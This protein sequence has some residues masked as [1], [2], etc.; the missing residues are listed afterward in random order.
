[1]TEFEIHIPARKKAVVSER[2]MAVKVTGEAY[3]ALTEIYNESTLSM[4]Q[5]A[6]L[7]IVEGSKHIVYDKAEV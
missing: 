6:S 7:L 2:D 3:N 1:M 5:I 4:R